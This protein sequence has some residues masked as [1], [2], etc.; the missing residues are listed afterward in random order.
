VPRWNGDTNFF[1]ILA[2]IKVVS[3]DIQKYWHKLT[4]FFKH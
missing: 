4:L 2:D 3:E 1:P